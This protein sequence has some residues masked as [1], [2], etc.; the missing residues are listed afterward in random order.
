MHRALPVLGLVFL[1]SFPSATYA[2][3]TNASL[4]GRVSDPSKAM[5]A[6]AKIVAVSSAT[7]ARYETAKNTFVEYYFEIV[8]AWCLV[9][10]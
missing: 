4:T 7:N 2:Q 9:I 5:I 6:D 10:V 8:S 1:F 3:S